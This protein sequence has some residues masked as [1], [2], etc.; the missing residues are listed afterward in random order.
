[1]LVVPR[2]RL[3]LLIALL[4]V[5]ALVATLLLVSRPPASNGPELAAPGADHFAVSA[6]D[7]ANGPVAAGNGVFIGAAQRFDHSKALRD[8]PAKPVRALP[9][10]DE[11]GQGEGDGDGA[12]APHAVDTVVQTTAALPAMPGTALNFN[13]IGF[14]GVSCNCA[15]PDTNGE[16]GATQ[17]VQVV[18]EG[19]QVWNKSTGASAYGPVG[20]STLWTGFGGGARRT[21]MAIPSCSTTS[22]PI[23]GWLASSQERLSPRTSASPSRRPATPRARGTATASTWDQ[24]SSTIRIS[25]SG[26]T[27]TT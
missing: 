2:R 18:N 27:A 23:A 19:M 22:S 8:Y 20:L 9:A 3:T 1:M 11:E 7:S 6:E 10:E 14:P 13:G 15:P 16:V 4:G 25:Q 26:P 24:T 17:Y 5:A 12:A 21:G